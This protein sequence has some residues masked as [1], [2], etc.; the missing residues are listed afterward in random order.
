MPYHPGCSLN[1]IQMSPSSNCLLVGDSDG[2]INVYQI[3]GFNTQSPEKLVE[4]ID[5]T[6]NSHD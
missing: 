5:A 3:K 1:Q 4:L 6:L 2:V